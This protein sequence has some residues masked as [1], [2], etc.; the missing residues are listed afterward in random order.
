MIVLALLLAQVEMPAPALP[1]DLRM[2]RPWVVSGEAGWNGLAGIG[3]VVA[4]RLSPRATLEAGLGISG[5]GPKLGLRARYDF[6]VTPWTPFAGIG[7]LYGTG[8]ASAGRD[9]SSPHPF[10]YRI[11]RSP[12]LQVTSGVEYQSRGGF[13]LTLALGYAWLLQQNLT[14]LSG[15]PTDH[16]LQPLRLTTGGGLVASAA[17]G[18]AF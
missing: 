10:S 6:F 18:F 1:A 8:D 9:T 12:F 17:A 16:D 13:C 5:E 4:H 15:A 3:V 2:R 14:I 7:F 11:G